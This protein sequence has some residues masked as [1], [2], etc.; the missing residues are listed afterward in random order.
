[1]LAAH[2]AD[3][4]SLEAADAAIVFY[5]QPGEIA[6]GIGYTQGIEFFQFFAF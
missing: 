5:L 3:V 6:Q 1:M 2:R 4:N